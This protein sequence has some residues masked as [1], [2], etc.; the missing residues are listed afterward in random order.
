M[1][2]SRHALPI[3][4]HR[5]AD[6][7]PERVVVPCLHATILRFHS[8][9][10]FCSSAATGVNSRSCKS[11]QHHTFWW[12]LVNKYRAKRENWSKLALVQKLP[13]YHV[14]SP[15]DYHQ[16][17]H[18]MCRTWNLELSQESLEQIG[19]DTG[20]QAKGSG[21]FCYCVGRIGSS[22]CGA[23]F[24]SNLS[25]PDQAL[26]K[27]ICYGNVFKANT[28]AARHGCKHEDDAAH[29]YNNKINKTSFYLYTDS[30]WSLSTSNIHFYMPHQT[31]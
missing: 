18:K 22:V 31:F 13:R 1:R 4:A 9:T 14:N 23:A 29:A 10:N 24:C 27:N 25:Q 30:I 19:K 20:A 16:L 28:K 2:K 7:T 5:E 26:I 12:H 3:P 8:G 11:P 15:L 17:L 6:F 21:F